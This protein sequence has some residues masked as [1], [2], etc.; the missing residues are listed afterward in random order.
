MVLKENHRKLMLRTLLQSSPD[1]SEWNSKVGE[2]E[3]VIEFERTTRFLNEVF[4]PSLSPDE[5]RQ[6]AKSAPDFQTH[7]GKFSGADEY[8][9]AKGFQG[10]RRFLS[11]MA[12]GSTYRGNFR[13]LVEDTAPHLLPELERALE[14][15]T[16]REIY[17]FLL[18]SSH[19]ADTRIRDA[20]QRCIN[21]PPLPWNAEGDA[22]IDSKRCEIECIRYLKQRKLRDKTHNNDIIIKNVLVKPFSKFIKNTSS[23][24]I[25]TQIDHLDRICSEFDALVL[26]PKVGS[27]S[28]Q[29]V[30]ECK[31]TIGPS[32]LWN[33]V[34]KK[35][36]S[37]N[38]VLSPLSSTQL[39]RPD[40]TRLPIAAQKPLPLG[41]YGMQIM[42]PE[43]AARQFLSV[44]RSYNLA[45]HADAVLN[46]LQTQRVLVDVN[47]VLKKLDNLHLF[48]TNIQDLQ[49]VISTLAQK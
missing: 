23:D 41:I 39:L 8:F 45:T 35:Y 43:G 6:L 27:F 20:A 40:G 19:I 10:Q 24:V 7:V 38:T 4:L 16:E 18:N 31:Y 37:M 30:W 47:C 21:L 26:Q 14:K 29:R 46:A 12:G 9:G 49:V 11:R 42:S 33:V 17:E 15:P 1:I 32:A 3:R 48:L 36:A 22:E 28:V 13:S 44:E 5:R 34:A 2:S 25:L